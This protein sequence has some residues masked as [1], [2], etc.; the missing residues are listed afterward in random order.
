VR[1]HALAL[2]CLARGHDGTYGRD[3]DRLPADV[4]GAAKDA[5]VGSL[6]PDEL[7]RALGSGVAALLRASTGVGPMVG[8]VE[9]QL[10]ELVWP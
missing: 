5:L 4:V 9:R 10:L 8:K 7:R 2:E 1:D 6:E 3:F